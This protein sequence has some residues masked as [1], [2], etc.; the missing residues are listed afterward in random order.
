[1]DLTADPASVDASQAE[2]DAERMRL[3]YVGL[4]RARHAVLAVAG[5]SPDEDGGPLGHLLGGAW[6]PG[7][8]DYVPAP[9][10]CREVVV[11]ADRWWPSEAPPPVRSTRRPER[12]FTPDARLSSFSALVRLAD[13]GLEHEPDRA[14]SGGGGTL[15]L[16]AFPRGAEAG[17]AVHAV[18]E[19][20]PPGELLGP[21]GVE[22]A[23]AQL[24]RHG[25]DAT[26]WAAPLLAGLDEVVRTPILEDGTRLVDVA[27]GDRVDELEFA[28]SAAGR[29]TLRELAAEVAAHGGPEVAGYAARMRR[30]DA[31]LDDAV[32]QGFIDL[33]FRAGGRYYV[34]DYKS[35]HLGDG[36]DDYRA[37]SLAWAMSHGDYILQAALYTLAVHRHLR[38][39]VPG[40]DYDSHFGGV[41]YL[42]LRGMR[43]ETGLAAGVYA[44]RPSRAW[45]DGWD[46]ALGGGR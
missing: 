24:A 43:P 13:D 34:V 39:R 45:I 8:P 9:V 41:R 26:L 22:V 40:Y 44:M 7:V 15:P 1:L 2:L 18:L 19:E 31:R 21:R 35:N 25:I 3:A 36:P 38:A 12:V 27:P 4:T 10:V 6:P 23:A 32:L 33:V 5:P 37:A 20:V 28:L 14:V 42:F 11:S 17:T 29:V 46:R 16:A 30:I